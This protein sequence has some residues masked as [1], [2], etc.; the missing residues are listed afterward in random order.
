M[1]Q[2]ETLITT[3]SV[4]SLPPEI[5]WTNPECKVSKSFTVKDCIYLPQWKRLA[6]E[7]DGLTDEIKTN[8]KELCLKMDQ[9]EDFLSSVIRVHVTF[10][11]EE[12]NKL[13]KGAKSSPHL[14]GKA[15]DWSVANMTC[16]EV[17][18]N[19]VVGGMLEKLEMRCEDLPGSN[20]VHLDTNEVKSKRFFKP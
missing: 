5:D 6:N 18:K 8:L 9:V 3:P 16:D 13:V 11:P 20:W 12:Y 19:L 4:E 2:P 17:R 14:L 10:R 1:A 7:Q 15:M